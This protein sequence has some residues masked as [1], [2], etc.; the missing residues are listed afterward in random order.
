MWTWFSCYL[1][2]RHDYS[3]WCEPGAIFLRCLHCGRRS[4]GWAV[5]PPQ[6]VAAVP[7][8]TLRE[9]LTARVAHALPLERHTSPGSLSRI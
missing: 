2:G 4:G 6:T 5:A 1:S 9:T 7:K 8:P 3:M